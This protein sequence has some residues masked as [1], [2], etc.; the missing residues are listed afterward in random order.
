VVADA[1]DVD[2]PHHLHDILH[3]AAAIARKTVGC[4][5]EHIPHALGTGG[6][7]VL[8]TDAIACFNG[9]MEEGG[10]SLPA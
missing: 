1:V 9:A 7:P 4:T 6:L 3:T 8:G 5:V 2:H 10:E